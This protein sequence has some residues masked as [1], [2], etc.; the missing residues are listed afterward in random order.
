MEASMRTFAALILILALV[1]AA[2]SGQ[3]TAA[4]VSRGDVALSA[5]WFTA[6]RSP[7]ERCCSGWSSG[8]FK[9]VTGGLYWT[10]HLKIEIGVAS[11]GVTE[12][13]GVSSERLANGQFSETFETHRYD[14]T[15][16]SLAHVYQFGR[17]STF[18]RHRDRVSVRKYAL[19]GAA[20]GGAA[21]AILLRA[22]G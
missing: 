20:I 9:G 12:G 15:K 5:G 7:G 2:A 6:D 4:P 1:P 21:C 13:Y 16:A 11:P 14:G 18:Q 10:D 22:A 8:L 17:N 19:I 3:S